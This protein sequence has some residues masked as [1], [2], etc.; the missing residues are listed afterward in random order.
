[1]S[2][3]GIGERGYQGIFRSMTRP[4]FP[5]YRGLQRPLI[6]RGFKGK[7]IAYGIASLVIGLVVGGLLIA[8]T[9]MY[10]GCLVMMGIISG[11]LYYIYKLQ[12][13]GLHIK[14]RYRGIYLFHRVFRLPNAKQE[15]V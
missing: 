8:L 13:Q 15:P 2:F 9:N 4:T 11:G 10:T 3:S 6:Y 7:F 5:V 14:K 12:Q 1:M